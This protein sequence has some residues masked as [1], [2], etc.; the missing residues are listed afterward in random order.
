MATSVA[1]NSGYNSNSDDDDDDQDNGDD[2]YYKNDDLDYSL[3]LGLATTVTSN[4]THPVVSHKAT[5]PLP[6]LCILI[7]ISLNSF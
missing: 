7:I 3:K 2:E 1:S 6:V 5:L 4:S